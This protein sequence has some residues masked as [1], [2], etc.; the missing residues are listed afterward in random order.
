MD[1]RFLPASCPLSPEKNLLRMGD[2]PAC[3]LVSWISESSMVV[4]TSTSIIIL[5]VMFV[6]Y[7]ELLTFFFG[8]R[9][10]RDNPHSVGLG[11]D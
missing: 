10:Q 9:G 11:Y 7:V 1:V 3:Q 5:W 2:L 4:T 8:G 6:F